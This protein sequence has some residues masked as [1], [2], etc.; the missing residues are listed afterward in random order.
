[1]EMGAISFYKFNHHFEESFCSSTESQNLFK[2]ANK[3]YL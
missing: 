1:M 3:Q 2:N